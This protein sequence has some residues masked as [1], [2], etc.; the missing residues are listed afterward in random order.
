MT[1]LSTPLPLLAG[2]LKDLKQEGL[3]RELEVATTRVRAKE[4][5]LRIFLTS[6]SVKVSYKVALTTGGLEESRTLK[7][8]SSALKT[9]IPCRT[10]YQP[11]RLVKNL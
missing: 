5:E 10:N 11:S 3:Q 4:K 1:G 2:E 8:T 7:P 9:K 6:G